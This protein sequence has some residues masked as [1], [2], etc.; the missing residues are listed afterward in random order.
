[1][2]ELRPCPF[3]GSEA[4]MKTAKHIPKGLDFTPT[5]TVKS[6]AGRINKKWTN[7]EDAVKA[8]NRRFELITAVNSLSIPS[9]SRT[10]DKRTMSINEYQK[11]AL[12]YEGIYQNSHVVLK[13]F[14]DKQI[15]VIF[16]LTNG[17]MGL[18][19]ESGECI[20]L[21]KKYLFQGHSLD[22][23]HLAKEL[24]DVA[25]YLALSANA[26]GY[27]LEDILQ[28]NVK[29]LRDRYPEGFDVNRSMNREEGD[30]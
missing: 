5:C 27:N 26:I 6:C 30:V 24:G 20:E 16:R 8:W 9:D 17:L 4:T 3:C 29:K 15:G 10:D 18:N 22:R 25:W 2:P 13:T 12:M 1:M 23:E 21:L 19:G 7:E 28:M 11:I 14:P